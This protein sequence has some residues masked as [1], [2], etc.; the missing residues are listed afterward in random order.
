MC[1]YKTLSGVRSHNAKHAS[2]AHEVTVTTLENI[3]KYK[4][5]LK[6]GLK[7]RHTQFKMWLVKFCPLYIK[8]ILLTAEGGRPHKT[9]PFRHS[10]GIK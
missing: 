10:S 1:L 8:K 7:I 4:T 3:Q 2:Q 5:E 6:Y 9:V